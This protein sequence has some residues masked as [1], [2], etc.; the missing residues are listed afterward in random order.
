MNIL[1]TSANGFI[2]KNLIL[3]LKESDD[4]NIIPFTRDTD[5][6]SLESLINKT[7]FVIHLAGENRPQKEDFFNTGNVELTC[8]ICNAIRNS[9]KS[10]PVIFTSSSQAIL[11]NP[12]G[13]S[14]LKAEK[15]IEDLYLE[16]GNYCVI[17]RLPG[18][19]GK[20]CKP[21]YN[22]VVAT[23]CYNISRDIPIKISNP[24]YEINLV[25][26]DDF[27][28]DILSVIRNMKGKDKI[29][30]REITPAYSINLQDLANQILKFKESRNTLIS[31]D[32]GTGL[33]RALYAT[34]ISYL[35]TEKF[36]YE[37]PSHSDARGDFVEM[38][39]TK[40]SGQFSYFTAHP[41]VTRGDHYHHTKTE[42]F[43][44]LNG[45]A[46]F[47][48]R[49]MDTGESFSIQVD[50]LIPKVVETIPGWTHNIKNIGSNDLIVML[51]VN[52]IF[53]SKNPDTF[54][55]KV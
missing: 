28:D 45:T 52:E 5:I 11:D 41:G 16:T 13:L 1:I 48:F 20:W 27:I 24:D 8:K 53:D 37:I 15:I 23:F 26:I 10:I 46:L 39:K 31:E 38:L 36:I 3:K 7:D 44:V 40:K 55:T 49:N 17:Y 6:D 14:K 50:H 43:L 47:A 33:V 2:D 42:K 19:F 4:L 25:Y 29:E 54:L 22:S 32:V 51:W 35:P 12:Y 18:V 30:R 34:Y 21:N 9:N